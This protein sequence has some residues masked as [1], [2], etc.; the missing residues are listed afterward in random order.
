MQEEH[1]KP[2]DYSHATLACPPHTAAHRWDQTALGTWREWKQEIPGVAS[3]D[4]TG[5]TV[6]W[7]PAFNTSY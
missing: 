5:L 7:E 1:S 6:H 4:K 2:I 3:G